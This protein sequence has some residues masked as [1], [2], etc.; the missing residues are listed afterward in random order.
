MDCCWF[1]VHIRPVPAQAQLRNTLLRSVRGVIFVCF[2]SIHLAAQTPQRVTLQTAPQAKKP[3]PGSQQSEQQPGDIL[4]YVLPRIGTDGKGHTYPGAT[5]PFGMVQLSPDNGSDGWNFTSGYHASDSVITGFSHTHF[6]GTGMGDLMDIRLMPTIKK[7][8]LP[9]ANNRKKP[10]WAASFPRQQEHCSPGYYRVQFPEQK[11]TVE[12]TANQWA[13]VHKY[14]FS[15]GT[16]A[17]V[18]LDLHQSFFGDSTTNGL[19]QVQNEY[20]LTG[21]RYSA[22][23]AAKQWVYFAIEFSKPMFERTG[24]EDNTT[25]HSDFAALTGK[26]IKALFK[27]RQPQEPLIVKVGISSASQEGALQSLKTVQGKTFEQVKQQ[28]EQ[29]WRTELSKIEFQGIQPRDKELFYT[30]LYHSLL[31]P[32][33]HSDL[34]GEYKSPNHDIATARNYRRYDFFPLWHNYRASFPLLTIIQPGRIND[35]IQ[36]LLAHYKEYGMLPVWSFAGNETNAMMGYAA[37]SLMYDAYQKGF[38]R[39]N[40]DTAYKAMVDAALQDTLAQ[41]E[42]A[43]YGF[44]PA[45]KDD[46][47]VTKTLE[48]AYYDWCIAQMAKVL[49]KKDDIP[50]FTK[51]SLYYR[52]VFDRMAKFVRPRRKDSSWVKPFNPKQYNAGPYTP[53]AKANSWLYSWFAPH[54]VEGLIRLFGGQERFVRKLDSLFSERYTP[55]DSILPKELGG[56]MGLYAHNVEPA[57]HIPYLYALAGAPHK[58]QERVRQIIRTLYKPTADGLCGNDTGGQ[59]SAWLVLSMMGFYPVN[60]ASGMYVIGTPMSKSLS[61]QVNKGKTFR[62]NAPGLSEKNLY[63]ASATLNGKPLLSPTLSHADLMNGGELFLEM[64]D[65]PQSFWVAKPEP[66]KQPVPQQPER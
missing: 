35:I 3:L 18:V 27:F 57:H 22:G 11:I 48:F 7:I 47:S 38:R 15:G 43:E 13:G 25:E 63:I 5:V 55:A 64:K 14:Q 34:N 28:A 56:I 4:N 53:F 9:S 59:I 12:L 50:L 33:Q 39:F 51:R 40:V 17:S 29:L 10:I 62:I 58:T 19:L 21:Y 26:S 52:N 31:S 36:S 6:S 23:W 65:T 32:V 46:W 16:V 44:V 61:I 42:Y 54:D 41:N 37:V 60:P 30:A 24:M 45:E 66:P 20:L 1:N 2:F 49:Q 8:Y